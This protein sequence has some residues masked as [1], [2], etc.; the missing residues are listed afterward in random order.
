MDG[1][2]SMIRMNELS[3]NTIKFWDG[4]TF[5]WLVVFGEKKNLKSHYY[6]H[7]HEPHALISFVKKR[8]K[9]KISPKGILP[10]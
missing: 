4:S 1:H 10:N 8:E 5:T 9:K 6:V 2:I 3:I 7:H